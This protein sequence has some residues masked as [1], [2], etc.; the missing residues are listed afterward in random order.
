[1]NATRR[2]AAVG[3]FLLLGISTVFA[4]IGGMSGMAGKK[5]G[6]SIP[7]GFGATFIDGETWFLFNLMPELAFGNLGIGLDVNI[8]LNSKGKIRPG[9]Y[10]TFGDYLRVIRYVRWAQKGDPFYT[11]VGQLDYALLGHGSVIYNYRNSASYDLRKTGLELDLNFEKYGFESVY[12]D[13]AGSGLFGVRAHAKPLKFT[14]LGEIPVIN[15]FEVGATY[16]SDFHKDANKTYGGGSDLIANA[17]DNGSMSIV[18]LDLGLPVISY[19]SFKTTLYLDYAKISGYGSGT[20]AGI[21][22]NFSGLG[23][24][25]IGAKYERRF[26]GAQFQTAYFNAFYE[27]DR[28]EPFDSVKFRSKAE[29]LR[30]TQESEGY[31][32]EMVLSILGTLNI[33]GGYQ[34]PLGVK[35]QGIL[36]FET[37]LPS[38]PGIV[39]SAAFDKKNVGPVFA[40]DDNAILSAEVGYK[41]MPFMVVSTVYQRTFAEDKDATGRVIGYKK[42]D[43]IEPKVSFVFSF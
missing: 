32:G 2:F 41:P 7:I 40:L 4:Q 29:V 10:E 17:V 39:L 23:L 43:R 13:V 3:I 1:M 5:E 38:I 42:Q 11:R 6:G 37:Q 21:K 34:A 35:N 28:F 31:Y 19:P 36:H 30:N 18:G 24:V 25:T 33:I 26:N 14:S 9:E 15:N 27:K 8:R 22:L 12:S 20:S 16:A